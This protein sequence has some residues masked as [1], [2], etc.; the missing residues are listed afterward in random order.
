MLNFFEAPANAERYLIDHA[1]IHAAVITIPEA[2]EA[3]RTIFG[4]AL[5]ED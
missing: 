3:G 1:E 5:R 4:D 2:I